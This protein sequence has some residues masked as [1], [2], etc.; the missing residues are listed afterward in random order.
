MS[1]AALR[2]LLNDHESPSPLSGSGT[3]PTSRKLSEPA[4]VFEPIPADNISAMR[5]KLRSTFDHMCTGCGYCMPCPQGLPLPRLMQCYNELVFHP[6]EPEK[7]L[8][9]MKWGHGVIDEDLGRCTVCGLCETRCTQKLPIPAR[10]KEISGHV[11]DDKA[12]S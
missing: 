12:A 9:V 11:A 4:E 6:G 7:L 1:Q 8:N 3:R 10:L 5:E 2:F